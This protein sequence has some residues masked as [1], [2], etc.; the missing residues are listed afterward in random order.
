MPHWD[1][2]CEPC[3]T[4]TEIMF[5]TYDKSKKVKCPTCKGKLE[6]LP[7]GASAEFVGHGFYHV[8][9]KR[10]KNAS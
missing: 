2:R 10:N 6:R 7:S 1:F 3:N 9:Y 5:L 8:D 4:T